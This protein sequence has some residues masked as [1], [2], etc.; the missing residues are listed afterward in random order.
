MVVARG[1]NMTGRDDKALPK[2]GASEGSLGLPA[3]GSQ[4]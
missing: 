2:R 3:D 4:K 1:G